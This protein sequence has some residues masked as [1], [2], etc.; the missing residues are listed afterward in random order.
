MGLFGKSARQKRID[1]LT[2]DNACLSEALEEAERKNREL[3]ALAAKYRDRADILGR[4]KA[5]LEAE[6]HALQ[7][8]LDR[9]TGP[10]QRGEGGRFLK[11]V[12]AA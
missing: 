2:Y 4:Q 7:A 5:H 6:N 9:F 12:E 3:D 10:R 11:A 8:K 1:D